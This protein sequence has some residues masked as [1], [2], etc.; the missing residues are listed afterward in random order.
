MVSD[1]SVN[2]SSK[3]KFFKIELWMTIARIFDKTDDL[4][5]MI[6]LIISICLAA[7]ASQASESENHLQR[8]GLGIDPGPGMITNW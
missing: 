6:H 8:S 2:G 4:R 1:G 5:A 7:A 3:K